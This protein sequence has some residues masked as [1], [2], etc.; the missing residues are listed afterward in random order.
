MAALTRPV[1]QG[2]SPGA[3]AAL[4]APAPV[5]AVPAC[6]ASRNLRIVGRFRFR[7]MRGLKGNT[8]RIT[9]QGPKPWLPSQL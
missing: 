2:L 9:H 6:V 3:R 4:P 8:V 1:C 7:Q 5:E